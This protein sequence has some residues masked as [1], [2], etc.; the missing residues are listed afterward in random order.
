VA[1]LL[2]GAAFA[3]GYLGFALFALSQPRHW[4]AVAG[5]AAVAPSRP[6]ALRMAGWSGLIC[7]FTLVV[8]RDGAAFGSIL[9]ALLLAA[10]AAAVALTRSWRPKT[11]APVARALR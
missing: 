8:L 11:L 9:G 5:R 1:E 2:L 10:G 7:A 4:Q 3:A 6:L